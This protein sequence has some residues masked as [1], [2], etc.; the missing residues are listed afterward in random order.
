MKEAGIIYGRY[1]KKRY[2]WSTRKGAIL[3]GTHQENS[4]FNTIS[5][6]TVLLQFPDVRRGVWEVFWT[7]NPA[8]LWSLY[9]VFSHNSDLSVDLICHVRCH[10]CYGNSYLWEWYYSF[11]H[12]QWNSVMVVM[13]VHVHGNDIINWWLSVSNPSWLLWEFIYMGMILFIAYSLDD[14]QWVIHGNNII[15]CL[16]TWWLSVKIC[17][18]CYGGLYSWEQ[19]YS[20]M[21]ITE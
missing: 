7:F 1:Q 14:Y 16:F 15:H 10:G 8:A 5:A 17:H 9:N 3:V 20:L 2:L 6:L 19:Y 13:G 11:D 4:G 21:I 12:Y 18:G